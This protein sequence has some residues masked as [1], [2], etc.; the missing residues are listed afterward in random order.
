MKALRILLVEDSIDDAALIIR[1]FERDAYSIDCMRVE[2][3]LPLR[4]ALRAQPWDLIIADHALPQFD[5]LRALA[6]AREIAP[7]IPVIIVSGVIGEETAVDA[8]RAGAADYVMKSNLRRLVAVAE[9]EVR[10]AAERRKRLRAEAALAE[11]GRVIDESE[12][13]LY[14]FEVEALRVAHASRA[15]C[16]HL[17]LPPEG[18]SERTI[19]DVFHGMTREELLDRLRPLRASDVD[20]VVFEHELRRADGSSYPVETRVHLSHVREPPVFVAVARE[21]GERKRHERERELLADVSATLSASIDWDETLVTLAH[22]I[23]RS[24]A[25]WCVISLRYGDGA[26]RFT[27]VGV[28]A[29]HA[30]TE[31]ALREAFAA[32]PCPALERACRRGPAE[33][34]SRVTPAWL[35]STF[36]HPGQRAIAGALGVDS[37]II[38]PLRARDRV[39]GAML[40]ACS[41]PSRPFDA[42][43]ASLAED[44]GQRAAMFVDN[45]RLY[46]DA[47]TAIRARD[48]FVAMAAHDLRTPLSALSLAVQSLGR[49]IRRHA[50]REQI[51]ALVA[52]VER[53]TARVTRLA[54]DLLDVTRLGVGRLSLDLELLDVTEI[55]RDVVSEAAALPGTPR[56]VLEVE[57]GDAVVGRWDRKRI[58]QLLT[59]LLSNAIKYGAGKPVEVFVGSDGESA[60]VRVRDHGIGISPESQQKIF[61]RFERAT[62]ERAGLGLGLY[63]AHEIARLLGG[64]IDVD[65]VVGEGSTFTV[66]LPRS[67]PRPSPAPPERPATVH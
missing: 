37:A 22:F 39:L 53:S 34:V 25:S 32:A 46:R 9:R 11:L 5:S 20:Q 10:D 8:M 21:I 26:E 33:L 49:M 28:T 3:E 45:A 57:E 66:T 2:E 43:A 17:G 23:T 12:D 38:V 44:L 47:Q 63:I 42:R 67:G 14:V 41:S 50:A 40:L 54:D 27:T 62:T 60:T 19:L 59:N 51:E 36:V 56:I 4:S 1:Q 7:T 29:E 13:E 16:V 6:V 15:A 35:A 48:E 31:S 58:E 52:V 24:F 55:V 61:R 18:L 30:A 64:R 65:S